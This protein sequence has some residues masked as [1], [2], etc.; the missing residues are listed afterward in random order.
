MFSNNHSYAR[1]TFW[2]RLDSVCLA[3]HVVKEIKFCF[4]ANAAVVRYFMSLDLEKEKTTLTSECI[5]QVC[6]PSMCVSGCFILL[7]S[8]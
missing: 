3:K 6:F 8:L 1:K 2:S 7:F 4:F 5:L